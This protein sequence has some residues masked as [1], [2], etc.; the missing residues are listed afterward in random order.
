[1]LRMEACVARY[2][3]FANLN[4]LSLWKFITSRH[5]VNMTVT[6]PFNNTTVRKCFAAE[7]SRQHLSRLPDEASV[8]FSNLPLF[9][10]RVGPTGSLDQ[11]GTHTNTA[12]PHTARYTGVELSG[13]VSLHLYLLSH[14]IVIQNTFG[15]LQPFIPSKAE[16]THSASVSSK[17]IYTCWHMGISS[18]QK[19]QSPVRM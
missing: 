3:W 10:G 11:N 5:H 19:V 14:L 17:H 8:T 13:W 4:K 1:M 2:H 18:F 6:A 7:E 9:W 16:D 15:P 12:G